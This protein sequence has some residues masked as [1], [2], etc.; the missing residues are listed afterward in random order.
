MR[1]ETALSIGATIL[2]AVFSRK[3]TSRSNISKASTS[4]RME[5]LRPFVD[6]PDEQLPRYLREHRTTA[7][8]PFS[9]VRHPPAKAWRTN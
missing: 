4:A 7:V 3:L 5:D 8:V 9:S 1:W 6:V 2:G